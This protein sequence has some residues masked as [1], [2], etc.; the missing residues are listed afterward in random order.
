M[1]RSS[2]AIA[3]GLVLACFALG[4]GLSAA[5]RAQAADPVLA[6]RADFDRGLKNDD[7]D[8][9]DR[10]AEEFGRLSAQDPDSPLLRA[11]YGSAMALRAKHAWAP[12]NKMRYSEKG[13]DAIDKA[14]AMLQPA[15]ETQVL[16]GMPVALVT[17]LVS[18]STFD[19]LP[20]MFHRLGDAKDQLQQAYR[21]PSFA[22]APASLQAAFAYQAALIARREGRGQAEAEQLRKVLALDAKGEK[23]PAAAARLR[24]LGQ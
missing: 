8:A 24:E 4:P 3:A 18:I 13:L 9:V 7:A 6:A 16:S 20:D 14:L 5:S 15:H 11:Y 23:A 1:F 17:R 2:N 10:A 12:W 22:G 21:S 19:G